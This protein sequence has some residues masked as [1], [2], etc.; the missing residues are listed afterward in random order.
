MCVLFT[1]NR[2][3]YPSTSSTTSARAN[4]SILEE[5]QVMWSQ[6]YAKSILEYVATYAGAQQRAMQC[7]VI[8][9]DTTD[10]ACTFYEE[11]NGRKHRTNNKEDISKEKTYKKLTVVAPRRGRGRH[12]EINTWENTHHYLYQSKTRNQ[13]NI[14]GQPKHKAPFR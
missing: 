3:F 6:S 8:I 12:L 14:A 11:R 9:L 2:S 10:T 13:G 4:A 7:H 5:M 1:L